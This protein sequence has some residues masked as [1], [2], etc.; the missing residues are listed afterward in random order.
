MAAAESQDVRR[1]EL[2]PSLPDGEL[3]GGVRQLEIDIFADAK[4]ILYAH[5]NGQRAISD[6]GMPADPPYDPL[7]AMEKPGFKVSAC[8]GRGLPQSMRALQVMSG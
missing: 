3:E 2:Q 6:A 7:H 8:A 1:S 5:P 4:G